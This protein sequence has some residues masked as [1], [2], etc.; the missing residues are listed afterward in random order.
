MD[1]ERTVFVIDDDEAIRDSLTMLLK[2]VGLPVQTFESG[3]HFLDVVDP[4]WQG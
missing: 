2:S 3:Q 1:N 4:G